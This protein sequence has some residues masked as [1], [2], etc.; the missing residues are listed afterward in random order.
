MG[1][2]FVRIG[3]YFFFYFF[4]L[5]FAAFS[6]VFSRFALASFTVS[7]KPRLTTW[8]ESFASWRRGW[9]L[10]SDA[11]LLRFSTVFCPCCWTATVVRWAKRWNEGLLA[12][13]CRYMNSTRG[14][15]TWVFQ[16][17]Y[18]QLIRQ[19]YSSVHITSHTRGQRCEREWNGAS[20]T[21][22]K[23]H[24]R[25]KEYFWR[26]VETAQRRSPKST[27]HKCHVFDDDFTGLVKPGQ[28]RALLEVIRVQ[29]SFEKLELK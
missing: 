15:V 27:N 4:E 17:W 12:S 28:G 19:S 26:V 3:L 18:Q 24:G 6:M 8:N 7:M 1:D 14:N 29:K 21:L 23:G 11:V 13:L 25:G 10:V 9:L 22:W 2:K 16:Q 5:C 20:W